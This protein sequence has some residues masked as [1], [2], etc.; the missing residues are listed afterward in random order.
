MS[1]PQDRDSLREQVFLKLAEAVMPL[2]GGPDPE[3]ALEVLIDAAGLL[4]EHLERELEE[5]RQEQVD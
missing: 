3:L 1:V 2:K 5:L 4:R